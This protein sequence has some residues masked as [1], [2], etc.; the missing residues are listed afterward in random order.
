MTVWFFLLSIIYQHYGA[1][2]YS[3]SCHN[4]VFT[5]AYSPLSDTL[6]KWRRPWRIRK[7]KIKE[8]CYL[9]IWSFEWPLTFLPS[10]PKSLWLHW[11]RSSRENVHYV[12][13]ITMVHVHCCLQ[14][15]INQL[16]WTPVF[17]DYDCTD[18]LRGCEGERCLC[19]VN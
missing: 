7:E 6:I 13:F 12:R 4:R 3:F 2:V 8:R 5:W 18:A 11:D 1:C 16:T 9:F 17:H 15:Q 14:W 10:L 19:D